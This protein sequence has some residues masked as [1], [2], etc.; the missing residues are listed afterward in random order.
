MSALLF[1][2]A[3]PRVRT[4]AASAKFLPLV[5]ELL[6]TELRDPAAPLALADALILAP[7]RRAARALGEAFAARAPG[8]QVLPRIHPLGDLDDDP[9]AWGPGGVA[10]AVPPPLS[11][12][13]RRLEL[14]RLIRA[15]DAAEGGIADP[16]RAL[17]GADALVEL[18]DSAAAGE[19]ADWSR[20]PD[21]V[22]EKGL[23]A[24]WAKSAAFLQIVASYWPQRLAAEGFSDPSAYGSDLLL[25]LAQA[26]SAKP[27]SYP[28]AIVGSTGSKA[29]TRALMKVV[30][31]LS[32]G[33]VILPGLDLDLDEDA[34]SKIG[35]Q[36][37]QYALKATLEAIGVARGKVCELAAP[38][39]D[40]EARRVLLREALAP[41]ETTADWLERIRLAGG[42]DLARR[43]AK[44]LVSLEAA[45]EDEE[46]TAIALLL[47]QCTEE[48]ANAALVTP[49]GAIARRVSAKLKRWGIEATPSAGAPV[50]ETPAGTLVRLLC[51]IAQDPDPV[52]VAALI[53]HPAVRFGLDADALLAA[54]AALERKALRGPRR[55][56]AITDLAKLIEA[57]GAP[58]I[59]ALNAAVAPIA[60]ARQCGD[61]ARA[62]AAGVE[63]A[64]GSDV[65]SSPD[66]RVLARFLEDL[67][68]TEDAL[69]EIAVE[70]V[71]SLAALLL[72][73]LKAPRPG[74]EH[75]R[76][77]IW[78]PL[79]ARLQSRDLVILAG[80]NEGVW[81]ATSGEDPFL[82]RAMRTAVGLPNPDVRIGLAAHDF[83]QLAAAARV[84]MIRSSRRG[85]A[86]SVA[87]RWIWRLETL[88]RGA[89]AEAALDPP[90]LE[91]PLAWARALD[92]PA[93]RIRIAPPRPTPPPSR[94]PT[95][96]SVT[97]V[98]TLIRDPYAIYARKVLGLEPLPEYGAAAGPA[99]RGTA[100]H[101]LIEW[102]ALQEMTPDLSL[103]MAELESRLAESGFDA[104]MRFG[105][106]AR[107]LPSAER[108]LAWLAER[109]QANA[110]PL[111][112]RCGR[113][114]LDGF[115]LTAKADRIELLPD[116]RAAIIDFKTGA[117]PGDKEVSTGLA[118]QLLLEAA[119]LA[120]GAFANAPAAA[121]DELIYWVFSGSGP[122]IRVVKLEAGVS[123]ASSRALAALV[124]LVRRYTD[125]RQPYLSKP[126]AKFAK[127]W[128]D[129]DHLA[130]RLEWS[131]IGEVE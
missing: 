80:L 109:R 65:W 99:E 47:R 19:G 52:S 15:R 17:A 79:E 124:G 70:D 105:D 97:Q 8:A 103:F 23:A 36:H 40:Q 34:W 104:A 89:G 16:V 28:V 116:G 9:E 2:G 5:A 56:V 108:Y 25:A 115:L 14:A 82:S 59:Q 61:L 117:A 60:V 13:R 107:L 20:L 22:E 78:G 3:A 94:R 38:T 44:G 69:G 111:I 58:L 73:G 6:Y 90:E 127:P 93:Q 71:S 101:A 122:K 18:L 21:L 87:S 4:I 43:G 118:P 113:L 112:E 55:Y 110:T 114:E 66:G 75:P 121:A 120:E 100:I 95:R 62:I 46:A 42:S 129:Y 10:L 119:M 48:R 7:N 98:E 31:S 125:E 32:R 24:H 85:G 51:A 63:L 33:V 91:N 39:K 64:A 29:A 68:E 49:D 96:L 54:R 26:W 106:A 57:D 67:A 74:S 11:P 81:P 50:S 12:L 37:P 35:P 77:A 41:P 30:A 88:L 72:R 45:N 102:A 128:A 126:R 83:S 130:R 1:C 76:I 27:P 84:V 86:P 92:R 53:G 123:E 131:A